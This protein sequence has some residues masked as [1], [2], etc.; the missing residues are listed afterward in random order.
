MKWANSFHSGAERPV[1]SEK[2]SVN[3]M[4]SP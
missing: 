2:P 4:R 1:R 3:A